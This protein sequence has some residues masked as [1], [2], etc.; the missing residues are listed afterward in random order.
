V[1]IRVLHACPSLFVLV[2]MLTGCGGQLLLQ[3]EFDGETVGELPDGSLPGPPER[4][5]LYFEPPPLPS[6]RPAVVIS[7]V[8]DPRPGLAI[9]HGGREFTR[10][11]ANFRADANRSG[12]RNYLVTWQGA[13][14]IAGGGELRVLLMSGHANP[15]VSLKLKD[16]QFSL[17]RAWP[18]EDEDVLGSYAHLQKHTVLIA[19]D[20]DAG[21][22]TLTIQRAGASNLQASDRPLVFPEFEAS[23]LLELGFSWSGSTGGVYYVDNVVIQAN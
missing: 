7:D 9:H 2:T 15:G 22:Y 18:D 17:A 16:G 19:V 13:S 20:L 11:W 14:T 1:G 8:G 12:G 23:N 3:A 6:V 4:D 10:P 5:V 21:T